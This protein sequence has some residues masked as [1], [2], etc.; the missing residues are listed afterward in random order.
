M[1]TRAKSL[2]GGLG[3]W[4]LLAALAAPGS[5]ALAGPAAAAPPRVL[6]TV[7]PVH[8][9]VAAVM[10]GV[11]RP[12]LLIRGAATPHAHALRP[13]DARLIAGADVIFWVGPALEASFARAAPTLAAGKRLVGLIAEGGLDLLAAR[14]AGI[15]ERSQKRG[16]TPFLAAGGAA[17]VD[18]HVWL[19]PANARRIVALAVAVL[20]RLDPANAA[21]YAANGQAAAARLDTLD[22][23]VRAALAPVRDVGYIVFHDAYGYF[24]RAYGLGPLGVVAGDPERRPGA[25][26]LVRLRDLIRRRQPA[27][28]FAEPQFEPAL[29]RRLVE[30]TATRLAVLDPLGAALAPGPELYFQLVSAMADAFAACLSGPRRR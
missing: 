2:L 28:L 25:G 16:L 27:C 15:R 19:D 8:S 12:D 30:G 26:R 22:R 7:K 20:G 29:A 18:P 14:P 6:V 24:E 1:G 10:A 23:R 5:V 3:L 4:T 13:S 17:A 9:L 11:G 21:R